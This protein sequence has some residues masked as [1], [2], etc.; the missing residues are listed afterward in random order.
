MKIEV[1]KRVTT[2]NSRFGGHTRELLFSIKSSTIPVIGETLIVDDS[3]AR[4]EVV[5]ISRI[6]CSQEEENVFTEEYFVVDVIDKDLY[7]AVDIKNSSTDYAPF[8]AK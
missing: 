2:K 3:G 8:L 7:K 5:S 1:Y 6:L 4:Y